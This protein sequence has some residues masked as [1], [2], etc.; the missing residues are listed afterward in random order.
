[1]GI[2]MTLRY[3]NNNYNVQISGII[4]FGNHHCLFWIRDNISSIAD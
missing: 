3:Y 4:V 1:M 2:L